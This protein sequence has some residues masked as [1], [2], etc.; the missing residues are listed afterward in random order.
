MN[1]T[2]VGLALLGALLIT[3]TDN[4]IRLVAFCLWIFTNSWWTIHN[5]KKKEYPLAGQFG[6]FLI[7]AVVGIFTNL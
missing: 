1:W 7:L 6:I 4:H 3:S 2:V 5:F